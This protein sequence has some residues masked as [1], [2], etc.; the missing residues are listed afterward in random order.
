MILI[1]KYNF[2][3]NKTSFLVL[4]LFFFL[5]I[6]TITM[7][8]SDLA[9]Q[10]HNPLGSLKALPMQLDVDFNIGDDKET[11][12]TYSFQPIFPVKLS[13]DWTMVSYTILPVTSMPSGS[14]ERNTGLGD[15]EVFLYFT[16]AKPKGTFIW[17]VGPNV[18]FP[19]ATNSNLGS[20]KWSVG[21]ALALGIQ[22]GSWTAFGLFDNVWSVGGSGEDPVN[23]FNFQYYITYQFPGTWFLVSN[24][25]VSSDWNTE[26]AERWNVP[27]GAGAGSLVKFHK[28]SGAA[29]VQSGYNVVAPT[30]G[31]NWGIIFAFELIF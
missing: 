15:L 21:P 31:S 16:P 2:K 10:Y 14:G 8:Q 25:V 28:L 19:T 11:G 27:L 13:E 4:V 18:V 12:Y 20:Q 1:M 22:N 5:L 7:A 24:Y 9:K 26:S 23:V 6:S 3:K 29:Y 17:G 30:G